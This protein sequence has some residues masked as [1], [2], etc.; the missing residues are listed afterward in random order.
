M[1]ANSIPD[2]ARSALYPGTEGVPPVPVM[3]FVLPKVCAGAP[4]GDGRDARGP[5]GQDAP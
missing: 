4:E 5:R 3:A 2:Y 1:R